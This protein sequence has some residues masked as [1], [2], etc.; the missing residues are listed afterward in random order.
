MFKSLE[1]ALF[2]GHSYMIN[3]SAAQEKQIKKHS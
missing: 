2:I 1:T 3:T